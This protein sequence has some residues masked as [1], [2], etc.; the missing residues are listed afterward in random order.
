MAVKSIRKTRHLTNS[1]IHTRH[2]F[3]TF[4]LSEP[5]RGISQWQS[6]GKVLQQISAFIES[7][8]DSNMVPPFKPHNPVKP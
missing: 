2:S 4:S 3:E 8:T 1:S 7:L 5:L 6:S